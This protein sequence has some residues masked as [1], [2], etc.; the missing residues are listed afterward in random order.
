M[1][2]VT[3]GTVWTLKLRWINRWHL[4]KFG[5]LLLEVC[6]LAGNEKNGFLLTKPRSKSAVKET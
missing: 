3:K 2:L 1:V 6:Y 5:V 4:K